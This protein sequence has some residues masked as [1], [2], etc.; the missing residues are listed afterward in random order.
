MID[1]LI[2]TFCRIDDFRIP[3]TAA[4]TGALLGELPLAYLIPLTGSW[5]S[6]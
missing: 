5:H 3:M 4:V 1:Q 6:Y 2:S